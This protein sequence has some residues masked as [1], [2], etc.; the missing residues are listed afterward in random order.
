MG[1]PAALGFHIERPGRVWAVGRGIILALQM[2]GVLHQTPGVRAGDHQG[3]HVDQ[4]HALDLV[5]GSG[6]VS[7]KRW[8]L[9]HALETGQRSTCGGIFGG[10]FRNVLEQK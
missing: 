4:A 10:T 1:L 8:H 2:P 9:L 5:Q 6:S 3:Q 7:P